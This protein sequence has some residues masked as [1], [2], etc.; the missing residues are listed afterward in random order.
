[1]PDGIY[2]F[3]RGEI[4]L[5][6]PAPIALDSQLREL[7]QSFANSDAQSRAQMRASISMEEFYTLLTFSKRAAVFGIR[8]RNAAWL[9]DRLTSL[10]MIELDRVDFR[11]VYPTCD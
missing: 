5:I 10:S 8:E 4:N 7:C 9:V 2:D 11:D 3:W 1:M 6:N